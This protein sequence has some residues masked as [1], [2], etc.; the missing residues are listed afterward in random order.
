MNNKYLDDDDNETVS[1]FKV[2]NNHNKNISNQQMNGK[3][4]KGYK[5]I[6][7]KEIN[8]VVTTLSEITQTYGTEYL[9]VVQAVYIG[10]PVVLQ[11]NYKLSKAVFMDDTGSIEVS[12]W[13]DQLR[14]LKNHVQIGSAN[15]LRIKG[16]ILTRYPNSRYNNTTSA[17]QLST[18]NCVIDTPLE[19]EGKKQKGN[20]PTSAGH[21]ITPDQMVTRLVSKQ[22]NNHAK[23]TV[24]N[25]ITTGL[26]S[27]GTKNRVRVNILGIITKIEPIQYTEA[28]GVRIIIEDTSGAIIYNIYNVKRAGVPRKRKGE[29]VYLYGAVI[30]NRPSRNISLTEGYLI[31]AKE[32][33]CK[34]IR[35][36]LK[37][38]KEWEP[39]G[40]VPE[41]ESFDES[42][43]T[44]VTVNGYNTAVLKH[45]KNTEFNKEYSLSCFRDV[46][47]R[48]FQNSQF[49]Y[50]KDTETGKSI[51][52]NEV[53]IDW[54][55]YHAYWIIRIEF[56]NSEG[57]SFNGTCFGKQAE[58]LVG[59]TIKEFVDMSNADK[60]KILQDLHASTLDVWLE[61]KNSP[62]GDNSKQLSRIIR[63]IE[64]THDFND[65]TYN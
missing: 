61:T 14:E 63:C 55:R 46:S 9:I 57:D 40:Y 10:D 3:I 7:E 62:K 65:N 48:G 54:K 60:N 4:K 24:I 5:K 56:A 51:A 15:V 19:K 58:T 34:T 17:F 30:E 12:L 26:L 16:Q 18:K 20:I 47:I 53:E 31:P 29:Y 44:Q 39:T 33:N 6:R 36:Q 11:S 43:Y 45:D 50:I 32:L 38:I 2:N 41:V 23:I 21:T 37:S 64:F 28:K 42:E 52:G 13:G 1:I 27:D 25:R 22:N 8:R 49:Y 35:Y 59:A